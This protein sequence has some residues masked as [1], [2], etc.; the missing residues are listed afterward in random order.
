VARRGL[1]AGVMSKFDE[2]GGIEAVVSR[3]VQPRL[4][5]RRGRSGI[6]QAKQESRTKGA[7]VRV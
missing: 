4:R 2:Q 5:P 7:R 3:E 1:I 6:A